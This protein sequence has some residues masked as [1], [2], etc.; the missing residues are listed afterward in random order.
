MTK[1]VW[2]RNDVDMNLSTLRDVRRASGLNISAGRVSNSSNVHKFGANL[3]VPTAFTPMCI[4]GIWRTPQV[5]G[6]VSLRVKAGG[7]AADTAAGAGAREV[8]LEGLDETGAAVTEAVATAGAS[9]SAGTT[10]TFIRINRAY[11]SAVGAYSDPNGAT[12]GSMTAD[13]V[14][15]DAGGVADWATVQLDVF[16]DAQSFIGCYAVPLGKT[17][18]MPSWFVQVDSNKAMDFHFFKR[19]NIL[20]AA[21]PYSALR[22]QFGAFGVTDNVTIRPLTPGGPFPALT[23]LIWMGRVDTSTG[24]GAVDFEIILEDA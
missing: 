21:A 2:T 20:Q 15:E 10:A 17:A 4:G 9:A 16:G 6:A 12:S 19:E 22:V 1:N 23:D 8:T 3:A 14:I 13:I 11:V 18:Y 24:I 5:A 7:N